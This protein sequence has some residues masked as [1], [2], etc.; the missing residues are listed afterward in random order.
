MAELRIQ[1]K[2]IALFVNRP[3]GLTVLLPT[4]GH[5]LDVTVDGGAANTKFNVGTVELHMDGKRIQEWTMRAATVPLVHLDNVAGTKCVPLPDD[6][7]EGLAKRWELGGCS[8]TLTACPAESEPE[9][10]Y[11]ATY[12]W[13][14]EEVWQQTL[15]NRVDFV[16]PLLDGHT[17]ALIDGA[18]ATLLDIAPAGATLTVQNRD[19]NPKEGLDDFA[20]TRQLSEF[21]SLYALVSPACGGSLTPRVPQAAPEDFAR[22]LASRAALHT[23]ASPLGTP[24][25]CEAPFCPTAQ[26]EGLP[27]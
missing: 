11:W 18:G 14:F 16:L 17:Y 7:T 24:P 23:S 12:A 13:Y 9:Y 26:C 20:E 3:N 6:K 22:W 27:R 10:K 1:F 4:A 21:A 19:Y 8:A 25:P 5:D 2:N 15:T